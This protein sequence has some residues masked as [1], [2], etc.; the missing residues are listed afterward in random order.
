MIDVRSYG[1]RGDGVTDDTHAIRVAESVLSEGGT[2]VFST[3]TYRITGTITVDVNNV[4]VRFENARVHVSGNVVAFM[5]KASGVKLL[6]GEI[7][8]DGQAL[9]NGVYG[10][11]L[12]GDN[13]IVDGTRVHD[14]Y[15]SAIVSCGVNNIIRNI[16]V[17]NV[18][19]DMGLCR[20][21]SKRTIW[22][23]CWCNNVGRSAVACDDKAEN[24]QIVG[25]SALN[26]GNTTYVNQQHN[27]FHFED[28]ND[29][30]VKNCTVRYTAAHDYCLHTDSNMKAVVARHTG[31]AVVVDGLTVNLEAGFHTAMPIPLLADYGTDTI[32]LRVSN[33]RV[34]NSSREILTV[35][36]QSPDMEWQDWYVSGGLAVTQAGAASSV[37]RMD[38]VHIDGKNQ[39]FCFYYPQ[40]GYDPNGVITNCTFENINGWAIAG[41]F[42]SWKITN[43]IF[44]NVDGIA[45]LAQSNNPAR[46]PKN[47]V[48]AGNVFDNCMCVL[49]V[50]RGITA[51]ADGNAFRGNTISGES[52]TVY[53]GE[54]PGTSVYWRDNAKAK[55]AAWITLAVNNGF[56]LFD[57]LLSQYDNL[58]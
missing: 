6:D 5:V 26:P 40:Y 42:D 45:L 44:R 43:N 37:T 10:I 28:C 48:I 46:K 9:G 13:C 7:Y 56:A 12:L 4:T 36:L 23:N 25:C 57:T 3:G 35:T 34:Y 33:V 29:G 49:W 55:G 17:E 30:L 27:V 54:A 39:A 18:G 2:L 31:K 22:E 15:A 41:R 58:P 38:N 21:G 50:G 20:G 24:M 53:Y 1:A 32:P 52:G 14:I 19:W 11:N 47:T 51:E 8:S 16:R